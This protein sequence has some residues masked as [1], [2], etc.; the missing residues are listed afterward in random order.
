MN[1][2]ILFISLF[3]LTYQL[4]AAENILTIN[5]NFTSTASPDYISYI[6]DKDSILL[7]SEVLHSTNLIKASK[8]HL[9]GT[10]GPFWTRATLSNNSNTVQNLSLYNPLAGTN[11][12]DVYI[13][14]DGEL[15]RTHT[16]GDLRPQSARE[17]VTRYSMFNL[18]LLA[19]ETVTIVS[20]IE[21][22]YI[23]NIGWHIRKYE[24]FMQEENYKIFGLG[25]FGALSILFSLFAFLLFRI[26]KEKKFLFVSLYL[27]SS[28]IYEFGFNG[29]LYKLNIGINLPLITA[30]TWNSI[31][32]SLIFVTLFAYYFF[33]FKNSYP[34]LAIFTKLLIFLMGIELIIT[35]YAQFINEELFY[36][37]S[38]FQYMALF[39]P[40]SFTFIGIYMFIKQENGAVYYL[41]GHGI[42]LFAIILNSLG[43]YSI[44]TY[45]EIY[46]VFVPIAVMIDALFLLG[47]QYLRTHQ[48][49]LELSKHKELLIEQSRFVS[50]GQ[51]IG[52]I[53]HQWKQPLSNLSSS[54]TL[55]EA[56]LR[57]DANSLE[58][59]FDKKLPTI[60]QNIKQMQHTIDDFSSYY[61]TT[62]QTESFYPKD[63]LNKY[64]LEILKSKII[65]KSA[66]IQ[67]SID[68]ELQL[69]CYEH[70]FSNI[71]VILIDN[72]LD[73]FNSTS[74][75][76][77]IIISI[78][79][80]NN[81]FQI[82]YIDNAG[83]IK[84]KPIEKVF[85]YFSSSK[86]NSNTKGHGIGLA[87]A[88]MLIEDKLNG[89][90]SV[91]NIDDGVLFQI[92][93]P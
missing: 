1:K 81:N 84:I 75:K 71:M 92:I 24:N 19:N 49:Q 55:L 60:L 10:T 80:C 72:S 65:L 64:V 30:L 62:N 38:I 91:K 17:V 8:I 89:K 44:I 47:A 59:V 76:N 82:N 45:H 74:L 2:I 9:G 35:L 21:N 78:Y 18:T 33:D 37:Y 4:W 32:V 51:A 26:Y 42:L 86:K 27:F 52:N 50:I 88:K 41:V 28:I 31:L 25:F 79:K 70:I 3:F 90:I 23:Y 61:S 69:N 16:L 12:I 87:I 67:L 56:I 7:P 57:N 85:E 11:A 53:T 58:K 40:V 68:D 20:K 83:G 34:K 46:K 77:Q 5:E 48:K 14:K 63:I 54:V 66:D 73:S 39:V 93:F 13:Y 15:I 22:Y 29:I 6:N 36:L 43:I